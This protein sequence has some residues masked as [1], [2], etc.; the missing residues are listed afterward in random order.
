MSHRSTA[1][2]TARSVAL[3][4]ALTLLLGAC[5]GGGSDPQPTSS[6][7]DTTQTSPPS[8]SSP[9]ASTT[10]DTAVTTEPVA[11]PLIPDDVVAQLDEAVE[12]EAAPVASASAQTEGLPDGAA[13]D[14]LQLDRTDSGGYLLRVRLSWPQATSLSPDQH[15]SLSLDGESVFVDGIRLVD[16]AADRFAL[17]TVYAPKDDEQIDDTERFRCLCSDLVSQV[18]PQGQILGA[19]YG[20]IGEGSTPDTLTVEVPGFEPIPD[21]PVGQPG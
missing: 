14:V 8:T 10:D 3:A 13:L 9:D 2:S 18:P 6:T 5:D 11:A 15:R 21:V 4:A 20:P 12:A 17:P 19:L 7:P 1:R 16:P